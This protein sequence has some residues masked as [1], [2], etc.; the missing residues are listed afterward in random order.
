M[1][2]SL[3][4]IS[5]DVPSRV[6]AGQVVDA[7]ANKIPINATVSNI[8][9]QSDNTAI[10]TISP[11]NQ[12]TTVLTINPNVNLSLQNSFNL[13]ITIGNYSQNVEITVIPTVSTIAFSL[14]K[15]IN[16]SIGYTFFTQPLIRWN[17]HPNTRSIPITYSSSDPA[18]V[19]VDASGIITAV[20]NT[21]RLNGTGA[22]ITGYVNSLTRFY[23]STLVTLQ[24]RPNTLES[25]ITGGYVYVKNIYVG[26]TSQAY[27]AVQPYSVKLDTVVWS[28]SDETVATIDESTGKILGLSKGSC[29]I[30]ATIGNNT[31]NIMIQSKKL[32]CVAIIDSMILTPPAILGMQIGEEYTNTLSS[33]LSIF[34]DAAN[35]SKPIW[36]SLNPGVVTVTTN[37]TTDS[38]IITAIGN[39]STTISVQSTDSNAVSAVMYI[40]VQNTPTSI[41]TNSIPTGMLVS[42]T[43][44]A[45]IN[46][47]LSANNNPG[48][49]SAI[50]W[51]SSDPTVA[52]VSSDPIVVRTVGGQTTFSSG[53]GLIT[54]ISP[55]TT[56]ITVKV[57]SQLF[58]LTSEAVAITVTT[59]I[60]T[61]VISPNTANIPVGDT[62]TTNISIIPTSADNKTLVWSSSNPSVATVDDAG[63][64][65][66]VTSGN[67]V[68]TAMSQDGS[69]VS[70]KVYVNVGTPITSAQ[71]TMSTT[72]VYIG[73]PIQA[74]IILNP[75]E[76]DSATT[77][78]TYWDP[79]TSAITTYTVN[80]TQQVTDTG[81][82]IGGA[83][84]GP[85]TFTA[86]VGNQYT[87]TL[88]TVTSD[89]I[90]IL[91]PV[92][93]IL[94]S[95]K[96]T[97]LNG[98]SS[99]IIVTIV[100]DNASNKVLSWISFDSSVA[101]VD[102][103]S[104]TVTAN[105][106][107]TTYVRATATDGSR[108]SVTVT[109]VVT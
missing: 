41:T 39:G 14:P 66:G 30:R 97:L 45:M 31:N 104:G 92:V 9:W 75:D 50:Q 61:I 60:D 64:I 77:D 103:V 93:A 34:P 85:N 20:A 5:M 21:V 65:T 109:V 98:T 8:L 26:K 16:T 13:T 7:Y 73:K 42:D 17:D 33:V 38:L 29:Y 32:F 69:N 55:G 23:A 72:S 71:I 94:S 56:N 2:I 84:S 35:A 88:I 18:S 6:Y 89:P 63:I 105:S 76:P 58:S 90:T 47:T 96:F 70:G 19:S 100:P 67:A 82:V 107:G 68:I 37:Y 81:L 91:S 52:T 25:S 40:S 87:D 46:T 74:S 43:F 36:T 106:P 53:G 48:Y 57:T 49:Y 15:E 54:A 27:L 10:G 22:V 108:V 12:L 11:N 3:A 80:T 59:G 101:E 86:S 4:G 99:P 79:V 24:T 28:S 83:P 44:Q 95:P 102:S 1:S 62:V 78:F 51:T